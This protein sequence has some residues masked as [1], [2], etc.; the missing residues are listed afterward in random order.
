MKNYTKR[1]RIFLLPVLV[2]PTIMIAQQNLVPPVRAHHSLTYNDAT[3]TIWLMGGSTPLDGGNSF[4]FYNDIWSFD[5]KAWTFKANAGDERSGMALAYDTKRNKLY[6]FG[7]YTGDGRSR[8]E[9]RVFENDDPIAIGW[10]NLS[11]PG[12][13]AAE[14]GFVY[15]SNRDKLIVFGGSSAPGKVNNET[16]EWDG[17]SWKKFEGTG[18][19]GRQAFVMIYDE[20]RKKTVL[21]GGS[22]PGTMY[23]DTW[24]YDGKSWQKVSSTGPAPRVSAGYAYDRDNKMLIVFGGLTKNGFTNDTWSYDGKEWKQISSGGPKARA[25][26]YLAYDKQRKKIVLFGGR[27]GWPND[28][29]DTWE[30]DGSKW[31]E[32]KF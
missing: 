29:N 9:F 15:D 24:E 2:V 16:W 30:W 26:G 5:G 6:S 4:K 18:P 19:E 17:S 3:K 21:F 11:D 27:L 20:A 13:V 8:S 10:K 22:I 32:L 12:L 25:M 1:N 7:G 31:I 28:T 14:P 23:G